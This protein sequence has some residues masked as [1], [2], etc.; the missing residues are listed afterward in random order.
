VSTSSPPPSPP[1][2][3]HA[4]AE[5]RRCREGGGTPAGRDPLAARHGQESPASGE[6]PPTPRLGRGRRRGGCL[7]HE[8]GQQ[9]EVEREGERPARRQPAR[10]PGCQLPSARTRRGRDG[11]HDHREGVVGPEAAGEGRREARNGPSAAP[12]PKQAV[13]EHQRRRGGEQQV[14]VRSQL[15]RVAQVVGRDRTQDAHEGG[16]APVETRLHPDH[17]QGKRRHGGRHRGDAQLGLAGAQRR[18]GPHQQRRARWVI[19]ERRAPP[20]EPGDGRRDAL[21][22]EH[23]VE[24][25]RQRPHTA[26]P[27]G[28]GEQHDA[29]HPRP[30]ARRGP[31]A[32]RTPVHGHRCTTAGGHPTGRGRP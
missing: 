3:R 29:H 15:L 20:P 32:V 13:R 22:L 4:R 30:P 28:E 11:Y 7:P 12:P 2:R 19:G 16:H 10:P 26:Q 24:P 25:R 31:G 17:E 5:R 14:R 18:E 6:K 9:R 8:A 1:G 27:Q 23:L 21:E